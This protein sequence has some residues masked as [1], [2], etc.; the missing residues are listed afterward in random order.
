MRM[1]NTELGL[2]KKFD[3]YLKRNNGRA[4]PQELLDI[5]NEHSIEMR[6]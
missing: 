6:E 5:V 3:D 1:I 4:T 2:F